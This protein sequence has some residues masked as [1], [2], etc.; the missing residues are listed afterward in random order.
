M[1]EL[2]S[3]GSYTYP[4]TN[5]NPDNKDVLRNKFGL[6]SQSALRTAEYAATDRRLTEIY[7]GKGP[8]GKFDKA[9][10]KA[11]HRH[12][13]QDVSEWAGHTRNETP[14]V[15]GR[16]VEPVGMLSKGG[17]PFLPG[18]RIEMGLD[19]AFK[20][21]S[22]LRVLKGSSPQ[23]FAEL[24]GKV[25]AEFNY[26]HPFREGNGRAQE[27][28]IFELGRKFGHDVEFTIITRARMIE[29]SIETAKNP[30]SQAM[31]NIVIDSVDPVR[32]EALR[33]KIDEI[34][35]AGADPWDQPVKLD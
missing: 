27:A 15:D 31:Q 17:M 19:E 18:S 8:A 6:N 24:A 32:R 33:R 16:R 13:F 26:V 23:K 14:M 22:D 25:L 34:H 11:L 9:H 10:L 1:S 21:I 29:A 5:D 12:V 7:Q 2:R 4:N 30:A 28:F 3:N 35:A 20:P